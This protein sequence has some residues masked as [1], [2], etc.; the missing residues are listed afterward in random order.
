M[1]EALFLL[2]SYFL[3][4]LPTGYLVF[5]FLEKKDIRRY[6]SQSTGATNVLR[7]KGWKVG[8]PV[9]IIDGAK[10]FIP[11]YL[12]LRFF[13]EGDWSL[14]FGFFA[15]IGH[16]FSVYIR[17]KGGKGVATAMGA[18]AAYAFR[19]FLL[20]LLLFILLCILTRYVSLAS[21]SAALTYPLFLFLFTEASA[22]PIF[23]GLTIFLLI[24]LRHTKNIQRLL[25]GQENK[26]GQKARI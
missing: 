10:G 19:P 23:T 2:F 12:S 11:V 14:L 5:R 13:G 26:L 16:C 21:L 7:L 4:S 24:L 17:F 22:W 9:L 20:S 15:V 1:M 25:T 8:L 18:Y 6:G 3:G